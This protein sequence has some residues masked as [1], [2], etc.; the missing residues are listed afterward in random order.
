[1]PRVSATLEV[2]DHETKTW[3]KREYRTALVNHRKMLCSHND[4]LEIKVPRILCE[5]CF[6]AETDGVFVT[7]RGPDVLPESWESDLATVLDEDIAA[8]IAQDC[9][10]P[11]CRSCRRN[12]RGEALYVE[13]VELAAHLSVSDDTDAI[14]PPK[15][16]RKEIFKLYGRKCFGC[17]STEGLRT[18]HIDPKS[19][20]GKAT[21]RNLQLL[22]RK[23][24]NAKA[25]RV[26]RNIVVVRD[27]W[28][29]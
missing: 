21:F 16:L 8:S 2:L 26:P 10:S 24:D 7:Y 4:A 15:K 17:G 19:N 1:M 3:L 20:G 18:D 6:A 12:L 23:C 28:S 22:C 14:K 13:T 25:N 29:D 5:G 11:R 9:D 27:P